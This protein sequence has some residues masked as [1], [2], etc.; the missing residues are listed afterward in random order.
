[1][2]NLLVRL[3]AVG[4]KRSILH[5]V[6]LSLL[7][8]VLAYGLSLAYSAY[9]TFTVLSKPPFGMDAVASAHALMPFTGWV[10]LSVNY[11]LRNLSVPSIPIIEVPV[12]VD[13]K[14]LVLAVGLPNVT[15]GVC[16]AGGITG[17]KPGIHFISS[18]RNHVELPVLVN[19]KGD[20]PYLI[21]NIG[22][23]EPL[24]NQVPGSVSMI[25]IPGRYWREVKRLL[26]RGFNITVYNTLNESVN[27]YYSYVGLNGLYLA[28][29]LKP[30]LNEVNL[31]LN[32]YVLYAELN[33][34]LVP[35][36][37]VPQELNF[38]IKPM[39]RGEAFIKGPYCALGIALAKGSILI[40]NGTGGVYYYWDTPTKL[41]L[42]LPCGRY[43]IV[44]YSGGEV[45]LV[46]IN[47]NST[48]S[49]ILNYTGYSPSLAGS[50]GAIS[51]VYLGSYSGLKFIEVGYISLLLF[52]VGIVTMGIIGFI[53]VL[54]SLKWVE[55][56]YVV[57][58][59]YLG[60]PAKAFRIHLTYAA[61]ESAM[62][63]VISSAVSNL[64]YSNLYVIFVVR[65]PSPT[66]V[67]NIMNAL[68][69]LVQAILL[70][71]PVKAK[72]Y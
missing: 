66:Y 9:L 19:V 64:M 52:T 46:G 10:P 32:E 1:M 30:G 33:G 67:L 23:V 28:S 22:Q 36:G 39:G 55:G 65:Q 25:L 43:S 11:A 37:I 40:V 7:M 59:A 57:K 27:L 53:Y 44:S 24:S 54:S 29:R 34:S 49:I 60:G 68:M 14:Y 47:L 16:T 12:L 71:A 48:K 62:V 50:E 21:C 17:I 18:I 61:L 51:S 42:T 2:V 45:A 5:I 69:V 35:L 41:N 3:V 56:D 26:T 72:V 38:T 6:S 4:I 20:Y 31:P 13:W 63:Y 8:G 70:L 58:V 15:M